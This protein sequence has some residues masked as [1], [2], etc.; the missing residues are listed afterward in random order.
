[1]DM[2]ATADEII[3]AVCDE[4]DIVKRRAA[5]KV[6]IGFAVHE[7]DYMTSGVGKEGLVGKVTVSL[8]FMAIRNMGQPKGGD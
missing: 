1:M 6:L 2:F 4:D 5:I 3:E 7:K 8:L